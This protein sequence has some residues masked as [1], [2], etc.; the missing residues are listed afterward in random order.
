[1]E[2]IPFGYTHTVRSLQKAG[3]NPVLRQKNGKLFI[4]DSGNY[5]VDL[6]LGTIENPRELSVFLNS[7]PGVVENGLFL[8]ISHLVIMA[9]ATRQE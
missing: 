5:I 7:V 8:K 4:T 9:G 2:I 1:M 3:M 6:H